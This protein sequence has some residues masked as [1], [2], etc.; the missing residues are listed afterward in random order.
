MKYT[1]APEWFGYGGPTLNLRRGRP[2]II[3]DLDGTLANNDHRQ[4]FMTGGRKQWGPFFDAIPRDSVYSEVKFIMNLI[5]NNTEVEVLVCTGRPSQYHGQTRDWL[6]FHDINYSALI[7]RS[8]SDNRADTDVKLD[9]LGHIKSQGLAPL[10]CIDDR[11]EVVAMWRAQGI[12]TLQCDAT[13]WEQ[14]DKVV[15]GMD[16]RA[17]LDELER[18]RELCAELRRDNIMLR[19]KYE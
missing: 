14:R 7:M 2:C 11:P 13:V 9:M 16:P 8:Q 15:A 12:R 10:F 17:L 18:E 1:A 6:A 5:F 4:H 19:E 3:V